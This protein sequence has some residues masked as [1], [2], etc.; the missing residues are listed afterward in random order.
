MSAH[1]KDARIVE[2]KRES[3][4]RCRFVGK[5]YKNADRVNGDFGAYWGQWHG[6]GWFDAL[7]ALLTDEFRRAYPDADAYIGLEKNG[8]GKPDDCYEYWIGMFLPEGCQ[9]PEGFDFV[10]LAYDHVGVCY[11]KGTEDK[12]FMKEGEC[13]QAL[14]G[15]GMTVPAREDDAIYFFE[16]CACPRFTTPD[17]NGEIILDVGFFVE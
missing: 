11:I 3:F 2:C 16:R 8:F 4:P 12:V 1:E 17:E 13:Y 6:N 10:D 15:A 14:V 5:R 7:E 9:A